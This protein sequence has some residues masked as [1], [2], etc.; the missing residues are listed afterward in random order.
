[1]NQTE[2]KLTITN[3]W[4]YA[5]LLLTPLAELTGAIMN[6]TKALLSPMVIHLMVINLLYLIH[7]LHMLIIR[8]HCSTSTLLVYHSSLPTCTN[9]KENLK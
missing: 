2:V 8:I 9:I 5:Y 4:V 1:M 6:Q 3:C 7:D